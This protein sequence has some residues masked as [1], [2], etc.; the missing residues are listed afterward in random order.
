MEPKQHS[1]LKNV[2]TR[3][4]M[5]SV[6]AD[7]VH[8]ELGD[9]LHSQGSLIAKG[10]PSHSST[11]AMAEARHQSAVV[12]GQHRRTKDGSQKSPL[13]I[14]VPERVSVNI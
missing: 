8:H 13:R 1:R 3:V 7:Q 2:T 5:G 11:D 12:L 6:D 9:T 10:P 14:Q 4:I